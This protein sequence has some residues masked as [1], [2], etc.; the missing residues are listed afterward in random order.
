MKNSNESAG[1]DAAKV[2]RNGTH[3]Y[4]AAEAGHH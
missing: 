1:G 3:D 2:R 4:Q